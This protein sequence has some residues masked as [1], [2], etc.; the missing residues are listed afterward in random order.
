MKKRILSYVFTALVASVCLTTSIQAKAE[1]TDTEQVVL[2]SEIFDEDIDVVTAETISLKINEEGLITGF[3]DSQTESVINFVIPETVN[4]VAVKGIAPGA[5]KGTKLIGSRTEDGSIIIPKHIKVIGDG[6]F[7][8]VEYLKEITFEAGDDSIEFGDYNERSNT[9]SNCSKLET[10]NLS[11]RIK[12]IPSYAFCDD[13]KLTGVEFPTTI[14][15]IGYAAFRNTKLEKL[16]LDKL[17]SLK[18]IDT[19]AFSHIDSL[20]YVKFPKNLEKIGSAAFEVSSLGG[21]TYGY[22]TVTIPASVK[23]IGVSAFSNCKYLKEITFE[24]GEGSI[25]FGEYNGKASTFANCESLEKVTMSD[26]LSYAS[27]Y[28]FRDCMALTD[29][30]W[31]KNIKK[32]GAC[33]FYNTRIKNADLS[34]C[35]EL[36]HIGDNSFEKND[37]LEVVNIPNGVTYIG[38]GAFANTSYGTADKPMTLTIPGTVLDIGNYAF[39]NA[40]NL[41]EVV[42]EDGKGHINFD[43]HITHGSSCFAECKSLEKITLSDRFEE[44]PERFAYNCNSLKEVVFPKTIKEIKNEAF[45]FANLQSLDLYDLENLTIIGTAAFGSSAELSYLRLP[46]NIVSIGELAFAGSALGTEKALGHIDIPITVNVIGDRAFDSCK[47]LGEVFFADA[48]GVDINFIKTIHG[49]QFAKCENLVGIKLS[50]R[51]KKMPGDIFDSSINLKHLVVP[52]DD[53]DF[54]QFVVS[55]DPAKNMT[56]YC[57]KDTAT[58]KSVKGKVKAIKTLAEVPFTFLTNTSVGEHKIVYVLCVSENGIAVS[59]NEIA[60]NPKNPDSYGKDGKYKTI[61]LYKPVR[62]GYVF[63]G[64]YY[65]DAVKGKEVKKTSISK[66][67]QQAGQDIVLTAHWAPVKYKI[68]YYK[69]TKGNTKG[70]KGRM[71]KVKTEYDKTEKISDVANSYTRDGYELVGWSVDKKSEEVKYLPG[72]DVKNLAEKNG[73]TIKLYAVWKSVSQ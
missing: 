1:S 35:K 71:A 11:N 20:L 22:S 38:Q 21:G 41:K 57:N 50:K 27:S 67:M 7:A 33:A 8:E 53:F 14:E 70:V 16:N 62:K 23:N 47:Y 63:K 13:V 25:E 43:L 59:S 30:T 17:D 24:A 40:D 58:Y 32:I 64:W 49:R 3:D 6:A 28:M 69:G 61:K 56:V 73:K 68:V 18:I 34:V 36:T 15:S 54:S 4:G 65:Y 5:F 66:K 10:V 19:D 39:A 60:N 37:N 46:K 45:N 48:E 9:F 26:R 51:C 42:F 2:E 44:I 29:I 52:F 12:N 31:S 72:Q 55:S